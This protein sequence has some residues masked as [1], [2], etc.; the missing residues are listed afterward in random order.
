[1]RIVVFGAAGNVGSRVV[2]EALSRGH[3][4]T[5][6]VRDASRFPLV[7]AGA[8][9]CV[10]DAANA[11]DVAKLSTGHDVAISATR[12]VPGAEQDL[13]ATAR[14]LLDG[15]A[16]T[17]VLLLLVGGAASLIVPDTG[18]F[19]VDDPRYIAPAWRDIAFACRDQFE[20]CRSED[21][22]DWAYL[23]PPALLQPGER[24]GRY[25]MGRDELLMDAES[26]S[27]ISMEDFA[28]AL[29]DEAERQKH[30]RARFTVAY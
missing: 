25:R 24:T 30:R 3:E 7:P 22:V 16:E 5:A 10:G 23:S 14:A 27:T 1:M 15:L 17:G 8:S 19:L 13:V 20:V 4:V 2:A 28:M 18:G 26:N 29:I 9:P 12:P 21:R 6:V 11:A